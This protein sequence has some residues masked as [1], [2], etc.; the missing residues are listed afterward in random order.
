M[1]EADE[2]PGQYRRLW[3]VV[4]LDHSIE[5]QKEAKAS[6]DKAYPLLEQTDFAGIGV[7]AYDLGQ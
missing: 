1:V 7:L 2:F 6:F 5:F 3:L 4:A